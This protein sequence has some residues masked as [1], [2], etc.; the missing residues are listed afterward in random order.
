MTIA[1]PLR[2]TTYDRSPRFGVSMETM[3]SW[4]MGGTVLLAR[5]RVR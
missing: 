5:A 3:S 2:P 4:V 1:V